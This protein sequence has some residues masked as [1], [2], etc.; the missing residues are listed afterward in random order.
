LPATTSGNP[1]NQSLLGSSVVLYCC[2]DCELA[3]VGL[4]LAGLGGT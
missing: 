3:G 1:R 2:P 4:V